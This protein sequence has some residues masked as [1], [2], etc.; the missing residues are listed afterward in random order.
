MLI[1]RARISFQILM[2]ETG[3]FAIDILWEIRFQIRLRSEVSSVAITSESRGRNSLDASSGKTVVFELAICRLIQRRLNGRQEFNIVYLAPVKALCAEKA[4]EWKKKFE[5]FG[6]TV[7]E[8]TGDST[9]DFHTLTSV[10]LICTTPEKWDTL[11]RTRGPHINRK[12]PQNEIDLFFQFGIASKTALLIVDEVH[13]LNDER[14]GT[15]EAV[16]S[17]MRLTQTLL[18]HASSERAAATHLRIV[19]ASAT[20]PNA[21]DVQEWLRP[22]SLRYFDDS[23]RPCKLTSHVLGYQE[24]NPYQFESQLTK[25]LPEVI[26]QYSNGR[27]CLVFCPSRKSSMNTAIALSEMLLNRRQR[28]ESSRT[29]HS[30]KAWEEWALRVESD[31]LRKCV[32]QG[33]AFHNATLSTFDRKLVED[34]FRNE[35]LPVVCTTTTLA[36]G[37]N[38][39]AHLV[40]IKSTRVYRKGQLCEYDSNLIIQ[41]LGRAGRPQYDDSG[42]AVIMTSLN[43]KSLY[44]LTVKGAHHAV[45]SQLRNAFVE[46][47]NAEVCRGTIVDVPGAMLW[48]KE[49]F[50]WVRVKRNPGHY[51]GCESKTHYSDSEIEKR[52]KDLCLTALNLLGESGL[53]AY[54]EDGVT[55]SSTPAGILMAKFY[56]KFSTMILIQKASQFHCVEDLLRILSE[57]E[58][59]SEVTLRRSE[60]RVL[61]DINRMNVYKLPAKERVRTRADK[62][63]VLVQA[64]LCDSDRLSENVSLML[65][66]NRVISLLLRVCNCACAYIEESTFDR[67]RF[68]ALS[69]CFFL[70]RCLLTRTSLNGENV[71]KQLKGVGTAMRLQ[72]KEA[73]IESFNDIRAE[74]PRKLE[75]ILH[76]NPPFGNELH[77][78]LKSLP[79]LTIKVEILNENLVVRAQ[80]NIESTTRRFSLLFLLGTS[81]PQ[82][83]T[84]LKRFLATSSNTWHEEKISCRAGGGIF[85]VTVLFAVEDV[86]GMDVEKVLE[87]KVDGLLLIRAAP[88]KESSAKD[89]ESLSSLRRRATTIP[90]YPVKRLKDNRLKARRE[91]EFVSL[92][93]ALQVV[94]TSPRTGN[95]ANGAAICRMVFQTS[96]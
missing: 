11:T 56:I 94:S 22:A 55:I 10:D 89:S 38:L 62:V 95:T 72:L 63:F 53:I 6:I 24:S 57:A 51:F 43:S 42:T 27:P 67:A 84:L 2:V 80:C 29:L 93:A 59:F 52:L 8:V 17:R 28:Q 74:H 32:V 44:D 39:P 75:S 21:A 58:E 66:A 1:D 18:R 5:P 36:Q 20:I 9:G 82:P 40:V 87:R 71:L 12:V 86:F 33:V 30:G 64:H 48:L 54:D 76:R 31:S 49:T 68:S 81:G 60:K 13:S 41:M 61:N 4:T 45:E 37:V 96:R 92:S 83:R 7:E 15:L 3:T 70:R 50:F 78:Q 47:V 25:R 77:Q 46:H 14:G 65:E 88:R 26:S 23:V 35:A 90:E 16:I 91:P 34:M 73:G 85:P 19:A 79:L 69:S